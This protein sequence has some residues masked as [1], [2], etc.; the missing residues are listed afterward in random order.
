LSADPYSS[1]TK[2]T[3]AADQEAQV[4]RNTSIRRRVVVPFVGI[5]LACAVSACG[6]DSSSDGGDASADATD[7]TTS[8]TASTDGSG[9]DLDAELAADY[10]GTY[11][12]PPTSAPT[13]QTDADVWVVPCGK[14]VPGCEAPA[15]GAV[16]AGEALGWKMTIAD[17][18]LGVGDGYS[19]AIR[20][21]VA[22]KADAI[23]VTGI[24]CDFAKGG[25][26]AAKDAGIPTILFGGFDC[27]DT[28]LFTAEV[29]LSEQYPTFG[30]FMKAWG[31]AKARW[32][33]KA[34]DGKAKVL[35]VLATDSR[36][37]SYPS[38]G[39]ADELEKD[40]PDCSIADTVKMVVPDVAG[41]LAQKFS[42]SLLAHPDAN[43]VQ[44]VFDSFILAGAMP[45]AIAGTGR[46]MTIVGGEGLA[47]AISLVHAGQVG[48]EVAYDYG[49]AGYAAIDT[50][51]RTLAGEDT[52]PEGW[53]WQTID[54]DHNLPADGQGYAVDYDYASAYK[55]A[56]GIS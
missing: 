2:A 15:E 56:W 16:A 53:G 50:T 25:L 34:T 46:K 30:D 31:A 20:Q 9:S 27:D 49:W 33:I 52:V 21:A 38:I 19:V 10:K 13:P 14:V 12:T 40:C 39:F 45:Q 7:S 29:E 47:P 43:A 6:S 26:Q 18:A 4:M 37:A 1:V 36:T 24:D 48:A 11:T 54:A 22:A 17:G 44:P 35:N 32:L 8:A 3:P 41:P 55:A 23:I 42:A 5:A 28:P 51:I